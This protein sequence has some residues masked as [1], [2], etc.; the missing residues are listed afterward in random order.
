MFKPA[1]FSRAAS[2]LISSA[3][4]ICVIYSFSLYSCREAGPGK[5][6]EISADLTNLKMGESIILEAELKSKP[7][8]RSLN[9]A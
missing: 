8:E 7:L 6:I 9:M 3:I 2:R 1:S 4:L 5:D